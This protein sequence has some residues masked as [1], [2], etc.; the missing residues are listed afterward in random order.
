MVATLSLP[1]NLYI[2]IYRLEGRERVATIYERILL[3]APAKREDSN[4]SPSRIRYPYMERGRH[5]LMS[6]GG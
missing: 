1:S 6:F 2:Y 3:G 5:F 4:S